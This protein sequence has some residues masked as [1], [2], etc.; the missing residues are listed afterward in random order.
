MLLKIRQWQTSIHCG[1]GARTDIQLYK[2]VLSRHVKFN[3][4]E[5]KVVC[6]APGVISVC[7]VGFFFLLVKDVIKYH[8]TDRY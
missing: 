5:F 7:G 8:L 2:Y 3:K 1:S 4:K 6:S